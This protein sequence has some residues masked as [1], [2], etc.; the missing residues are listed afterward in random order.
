MKT[1]NVRRLTATIGVVLL[2]CLARLDEPGGA[3]AQQCAVALCCVSHYL[4]AEVSLW[5]TGDLAS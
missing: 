4:S 2:G 3:F 5:L 1:M